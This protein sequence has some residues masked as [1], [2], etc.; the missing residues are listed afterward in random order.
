MIRDGRAGMDSGMYAG[1]RLERLGTFA[2][3]LVAAVASVATSAPPEWTITSRID[4]PTVVLTPSQ[5]STTFHAV[6]RASQGPSIDFTA[7]PHVSTA[8]AGSADAQPDA[9]TTPAL[10]LSV[11]GGQGTQQGTIG[12]AQ[13]TLT[14]PGVAD[15]ASTCAYDITVTFAL[16]GGT[17]PATT[18]SIDWSLRASL[19]SSEN[20]DEAVELEL[21]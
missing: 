14:A 10:T 21:Q 2:G 17:G 18:E 5:P 3:L 6:A 11:S 4:G 16:D 9:G 1:M 12:N 15:C 19:T 7:T 20:V 13:V 8:D